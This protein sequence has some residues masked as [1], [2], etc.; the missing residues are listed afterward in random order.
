MIDN[1]GLPGAGAASSERSV[2]VGVASELL[3]DR[4]F[5]VCNSNAADAMPLLQAGSGG[6][7]VAGKLAAG[8]LQD[9]KRQQQGV[10]VILEPWS[11]HQYRATPKAPFSADGLNTV[12]TVAPLDALLDGQR[13]LGSDLAMTPTG[14]IAVGDAASL[15]AAID[16]VNRL[17]R[18]DMI[19]ALPMDGNWLSTQEATDRLIREVNRSKHPVAL[20]F[21]SG[22][23]PLQS[24]KRKLAYRR[25]FAGITSEVIAYRTDLFGFDAL[26]LGAKAAAIGA[27]PA[28]WRIN[29]VG[30]PS[31]GYVE[32]EFKAPQILIGDLLSFVRSRDMRNEW[33]TSSPSIL[34]ACR[35]CKGEPIDRLF[36][37]DDH[38]SEGQR[39][40]VLEIDRIFAS[41]QGLT[42][43]AK[44][45][46]WRHLVVGAR[47]A[48]TQLST[49][50]EK[51]IGVPDALSMWSEST[52][53]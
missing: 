47:N 1:P 2:E 27:L 48:Y 42:P 22:G 17:D 3:K 9:L 7:F 20:G 35:E 18:T 25:A 16:Q 23:H 29:P 34:C 11:L 37:F 46:Q 5:H 15:V 6:M 44:Q 52:T 43:T 30:V 38:R 4:Q 26:A 53:C 10:P 45:Q 31:G 14:Q 12:A 49:Y 32:E 40:N 28:A 8:K 39:H 13:A 50:L 21:T 24:H 41:L 19:L 36:H 51:D 33:F